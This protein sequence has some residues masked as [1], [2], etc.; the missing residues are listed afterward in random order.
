MTFLCFLGE[1]LASLVALHMGPL[2]S[3]KAYG[4][5]LNTVGNIQEQQE[6]TFYYDTNFTGETNY[7]HK[8]D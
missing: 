4:V 1:S 2:V 8:D 5:A 7:S 3:F 6:I